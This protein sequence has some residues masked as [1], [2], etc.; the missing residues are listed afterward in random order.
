MLRAIFEGLMGSAFVQ[1]LRFYERYSLPI[2]AVIVA[3]GFVMVFS[4][5]NLVYIRRRL[6]SAIVDQMRQHSDLGPDVKPKRVLKEITI[7]WQEALAHARF[8]L[9][10][11][12]V[13]FWPRRCTLDTVQTLL[14]EED[15]AREALTMLAELEQRQHGDT[16][17]KEER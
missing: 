15:L 1:V 12:Q 2:N 8:P 10:A 5:S 11:K 16:S 14:P 3:Y 17:S 4:W 9:V 6:V 7:P 13:A